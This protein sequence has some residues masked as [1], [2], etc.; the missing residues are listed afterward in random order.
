MRFLAALFN[1]GEPLLRPKLL[2]RAIE[3]F[4]HNAVLTSG[5]L[6]IPAGLDAG[7]L[8][9]L[10]GQ[11]SMHDALRG[12]GSYDAVLKNLRHQ[13]DKKVLLY[14]TLTTANRD[15]TRHLPALVEKTGARGALVNFYAGKSG[16]PLLL[17]HG[18]RDR[19]IDELLEMT[20]LHPE[21]LLNPPGALE[22]LRTQSHEALAGS[23]VFQYGGLAVDE[24]LQVKD[25]C[26]YGEC[27]SC[28]SCGLAVAG[29][30]AASAMGDRISKAM[31]DVI[32][33]R[34]T[35]FRPLPVTE[36]SDP[37]P[38]GNTLE[39]DGLGITAVDGS[40]ISGDFPT[41]VTSED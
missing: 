37:A 4:E 33:P 28:E 23:C 15:A 40:V 36:E 12:Q 32:F 18:D 13:P 3:Y 41:Q 30:Y 9:V 35:G 17:E 38:L 5:V 10:D 1:G 24:Q 31:L 20:D 29:M 27:S 11:R 25:P 22:L 19:V 21:A 2:M 26:V 8:V 39:G 16:D 34:K 7:I 6:P 14:V